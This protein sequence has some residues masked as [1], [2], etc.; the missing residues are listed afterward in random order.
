[1]GTEVVASFL[2]LEDGFFMLWFL[3]FDQG[4]NLSLVVLRIFSLFFLRIIPGVKD[5]R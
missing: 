4:A 5:L 1:M 2:T 3:K